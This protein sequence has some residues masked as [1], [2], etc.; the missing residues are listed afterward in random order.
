MGRI[1]VNKHF[2][3]KS[4][5]T[6]ESFAHKGEIIISNEVGFEG[7]FI[8]NNNGEIFYIAPTEGAGAD[9]PLEYKEYIEKFV[10]ENAE[11]EMVA[12]I[13]AIIKFARIYS[14]KEDG[15]EKIGKDIT[16]TEEFETKF[17]KVINT[18]PFEYLEEKFN[19]LKYS[20]ILTIFNWDVP[21]IIEY[22]N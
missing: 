11:I 12:I 9:V 19:G 3:V 15:R 20:E 18:F 21:T 10:N 5:I 16:R 7:I 22:F 8:K 4:N 6:P 2:D 17:L 13:I 14:R 1:V